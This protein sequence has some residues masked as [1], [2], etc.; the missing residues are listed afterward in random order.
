MRVNSVINRI[1]T[2]VIFSLFVPACDQAG[3]PDNESK[4]RWQKVVE[5]DPL[6]G[7]KDIQ[8]LM[9]GDNRLSSQENKV[10]LVLTCMQGET[11]AY[12]VWRQYLGVYDP[13]VTWRVGSD[14]S[15]VE[16]WVLSTDSEA[17]F[18]PR[19]VELIKQMLNS[20]RGQ[21]R[22]TSSQV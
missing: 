11:S 5:I 20:F 15:V 13:E 8:M 14:P 4:P 3:A 21:C 7:A 9:G 18:A 22:I 6:D 19:P 10:I 2:V 12:V 1:A 17:T 16:T